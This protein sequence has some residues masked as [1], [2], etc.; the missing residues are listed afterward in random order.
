MK[1]TKKLFAL[2]LL[3]AM[4]LGVSVAT[5]ATLGTRSSFASVFGEPTEHTHEGMTPWGDASGEETSLPNAAGKYY[6]TK[7]ITI[8]NVWS[9]NASIDLCLNGHSITK[10]GSINT[11]IRTSVSDT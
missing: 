7:D 9:V 3:P 4:A 10:T 2:L 8:N 1:P 11:V 5:I 6:L